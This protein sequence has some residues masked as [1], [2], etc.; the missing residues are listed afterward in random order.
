MLYTTAHQCFPAPFLL[1]HEHFPGLSRPS[2]R[3]LRHATARPEQNQQ[4]GAA[5][6]NC[7]ATLAGSSVVGSRVDH[8]PCS[9][10]STSPRNQ[11][12]LV[13]TR[14]QPHQ[15]PCTLT[16]V[17]GTNG[18][19]LTTDHVPGPGSDSTVRTCFCFSAKPT[20]SVLVPTICNFPLGP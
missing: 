3:A 18:S 10:C 2:E 9:G 12:A 11:R 16:V 14:P 13:R 15:S 19:A 4:H 5:K 20:V 8:F 7:Q 6:L 1:S 17:T